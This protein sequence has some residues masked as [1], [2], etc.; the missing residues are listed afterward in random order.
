MD[1]RKMFFGHYYQQPCVSQH[2]MM[3]AHYFHPVAFV[4]LTVLFAILLIGLLL[5]V[6]RTAVTPVVRAREL[7]PVYVLEQLVTAAIQR[8]SEMNET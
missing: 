2:Q 4:A 5:L 6:A 8:Y 3:T 7:K 1:E